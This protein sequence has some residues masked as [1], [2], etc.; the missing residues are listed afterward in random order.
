MKRAGRRIRR[1]AWCACAGLTLGWF[2]GLGPALAEPRWPV[3]S[4]AEVAMADPAPA[5]VERR[6]SDA[7]VPE[8]VEA[9]SSGER[10][11]VPLEP[12]P[13]F[14][15]AALMSPDLSDGSMNPPDGTRV[16]L[17]SLVEEGERGHASWYGSWHHGR[18]TASGERFDMHA[19]TAAHPNLP[20]GTRVRVRRLDTGAEVE[21]RINDRGPFHRKRIIDLSRAAAQ[22]LDLLGR[23]VAEVQLL[24]VEDA[25]TT[26]AER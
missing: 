5:A 2:A 3:G 22:A 16:P 13:D 21:V 8:P 25:T 14:E 23:G 4:A 15:P 18:R 24:R 26:A 1:R 10:P 19:L 17:P 11:H 9:G 20:F 6:A 12:R 7:R